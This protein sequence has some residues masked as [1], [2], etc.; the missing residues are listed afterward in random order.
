MADAKSANNPKD[1]TILLKWI[2]MVPIKMTVAAEARISG[3]IILFLLNSLKTSASVA[4]EN[5][6]MAAA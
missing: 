1:S 2:Y 3:P 4:T 5:N 6:D